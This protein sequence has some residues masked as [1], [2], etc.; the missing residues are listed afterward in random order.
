M[1]PNQGEPNKTAWAIFRLNPH[2]LKDA[3]RALDWIDGQ[4]FSGR[5]VAARGQFIWPNQMVNRPVQASKLVALIERM[6][7][8][9][10]SLF[11]FILDICTD[12]SLEMVL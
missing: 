12:Q 4:A 9:W 5:E 7:R 11:I 1:L 3:L 6:P 8:A 10:A 2:L